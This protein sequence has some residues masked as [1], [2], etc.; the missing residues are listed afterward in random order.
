M[1]ILCVEIFKPCILHFAINYKSL[2]ISL[3][4]SQQNVETSLCAI[5]EKGGLGVYG[6]ILVMG[7]HSDQV[8][9]ELLKVKFSIFILI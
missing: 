1:A 7:Q 9:L 5:T 8:T 3:I 2:L 4:A 6:S